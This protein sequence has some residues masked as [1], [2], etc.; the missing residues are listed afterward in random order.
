MISTALIFDRRKTASK[1]RKGVVEIRL[2]INRK[3][4]YISTGVRVFPNKWNEGFVVKTP[5]SDELNERL[6]VYLSIANQTATE[7]IKSGRGIDAKAIKEKLTAAVSS[8]GFDRR[9]MVKW[10]SEQVDTLRV[11]PGTKKHYVTLI[12]RLNEY[13][14]LTSWSDL[15]IEKL[16]AWDAWLHELPTERNST[17]KLSDGGVWT[18]HKSMKALLNRAMMFGKI[19][20]NPYDRLRGK[21]KRGDNENT[22]Y[23]TEAEVKKLMAKKWKTGSELGKARDLF[24]FQAYTG[25][26]YGDTQAFNIDDYK[27]VNGRW[28]NNGERIKTGVAYVSELLPPAVDVLERYDMKVPKISNQAYNRALKVVGEAAGI[29]TPLH[30]HLARHTFATMMLRMGAKIE[31]VSRM[32]GHTNIKQTQRYAKVLA[33]SVHDDFEMVREKMTKRKNK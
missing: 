25:L 9:G 28:V 1:D 19:D 21:F 23:L 20:K 4:Y 24:I 14:K 30:S 26:S 11:A 3:S 5:D 27:E 33:E 13:N 31:N 6:R 22:E 7:Q 15:T 16:Y 18:Y 29:S 8:S 17:G 2:T 10:M 12:T 32:L